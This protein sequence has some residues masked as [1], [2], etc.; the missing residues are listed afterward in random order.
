MASI[1]CMVVALL[2]FSA[3]FKFVHA[4]FW[5]R[6]KRMKLIVGDKSDSSWSTRPWVM[7]KHMGI[8]YDA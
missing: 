7:L 3:V 1:D 6:M 4:S 5:W 8:H 2:P